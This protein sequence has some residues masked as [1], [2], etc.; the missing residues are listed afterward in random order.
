M[1][2]RL[3]YL[4]AVLLGLLLASGWVAAQVDPVLPGGRI[5]RNP[6][7]RDNL[8]AEPAVSPDVR[9]TV[10]PAAGVVDPRDSTTRPVIS[11]SATDG[12]SVP[13]P[14]TAAQAPLPAPAASAPVGSRP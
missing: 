13:V 4:P 10:I 6:V 5:N 2:K 8:P 9:D 7:F 14:G 1:N 3:R 12:R 11:P